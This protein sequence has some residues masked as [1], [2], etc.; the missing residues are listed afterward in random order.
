[1]KEIEPGGREKKT[2]KIIVGKTE[3]QRPRHKCEDNIKLILD[4][5]RRNGEELASSGLI[6]TVFR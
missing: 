2:S 6:Y 3:R 1:M 4:R 5:L